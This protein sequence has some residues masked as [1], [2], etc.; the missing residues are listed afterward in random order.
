[1]RAVQYRHVGR[2]PQAV[3]LPTPTPGPGEVLV[4]TAAAGLCHSDLS[5]MAMPADQLRYSLPLTL[6]H[7]GVGTVAAVGDRV[8]AV[9]VGDDVAVHLAWGCGRCPSCL[10]GHENYCLRITREGRIGPGLGWP[11]T[12]AEFVLVPDAR[13]LVPLRGLDPVQAVPLTD[14]GLTPYHAVKRALP[15]LVPGSTAVVLGV[16]GLGHMAV[17]ILRRLTAARVVALDVSEE[18][19]RLAASVGAHETVMCDG[20]AVPAVLKLT[21]GYGAE[22]V[23][24]FVGSRATLAASAQLVAVEG[25]I[26]VIGMG[27]GVVAVG[28]GRVPFAAS[29][30]VPFA[31]SRTDLV[32]V[33]EL[34][35]SGSLQAHVQTFGLDEAPDAYDLL[36][37]GRIS[38]RAVVVF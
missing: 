9:A 7:E 10:R 24:D 8:S 11:G 30:S 13:H 23:F 17:Q 36:H 37:Q 29:V 32:E 31:G 34:A 15:R 5:L 18:K 6:G 33:L 35:R 19:L 20:D 22:V 26:S 14:A 27:G 16:G 12:L 25:E 2:P 4:K 3:D 1:M 28:W 21:E 38:G